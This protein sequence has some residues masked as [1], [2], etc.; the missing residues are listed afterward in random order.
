MTERQ[1]I[2]VM[3]KKI[4]LYMD[5]GGICEVCGK[6]VELSQ[7][8]LGHRFPKTK[9]NIR[10]YGKDITHHSY[11]LALVCS[12]KCNSAVNISNKPE[13]IK[14]LVERI[15]LNIDQNK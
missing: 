11:N 14:V 15:K 4:H 9:Y 1:K 5:R 12:L 3:E 10:K 13:E 6:P 8:Q 7:A 2:E